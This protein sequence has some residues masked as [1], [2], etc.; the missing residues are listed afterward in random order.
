MADFED[1]WIPYEPQP[2]Q[3]VNAEPSR[4]EQLPQTCPWEEKAPHALG[5]KFRNAEKTQSKKARQVFFDGM[6]EE[7]AKV[8][9]KL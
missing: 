8:I 1:P 9:H 7:R 6:L 5:M 2:T 4:I 3:L